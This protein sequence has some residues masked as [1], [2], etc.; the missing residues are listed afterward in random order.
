MTKIAIVGGGIAGLAL[1]AMLDPDQHEVTVHEQEPDRTSL[2]TALAI[3]PGARR[4]LAAAGAA[5]VLARSGSATAASL[6]T[7]EGEPLVGR[8]LPEPL[9]LVGRDALLRAL[10]DAVP[11][12]V[13]RETRR[14]ESP[15]AL[16]AD[17]VVA[18]DGV[19]SAVRR[20][21]WGPGASSRL[22]EYLAVRGLVDGPIEGVREHWGGGRLF[23]LTPVGHDPSRGAEDAQP[24][25]LTNWF[26]AY[27]SELGPR[28]VP[29]DE[30]LA[31]AGHRF[32]GAAPAIRRTLSAA[33]PERTL[34]Q[35]IWLAPP[36]RSYVRG[37]VVLV[38][39]AAHA[40]TPNL[41]RGACEALVDAH[42]LARALNDRET[43][44]GTALHRYDRR[45]VLP[46][47]VARASSS[48]VASVALAQRLAPPRDAALRAVGK[49]VGTGS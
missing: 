46:T 37:R 33:D 41:G 24:G 28:A 18:A 38:G 1:A 2:G 25:S 17:L 49:V 7:V 23:G 32:A 9:P 21:V 15:D 26:C 10:S 12:T 27:R 3:W 39:D 34:A 47:Q 6:L 8:G 19:H 14:V 16:D 36:L 13:V 22:T 5:E 30:A 11:Q 42:V 29:V 4:A 35:R 48:A 20:A 31:D 45:R 40:M 44:L 43:D